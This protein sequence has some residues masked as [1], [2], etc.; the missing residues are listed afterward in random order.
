MDGQKSGFFP[1]FLLLHWPSPCNLQGTVHRLWRYSGK[2]WLSQSSFFV[3]ADFRQSRSWARETR[4][5]LVDGVFWSRVYS[6]VYPFDLIQFKFNFELWSNL[7]VLR[8][9]PPY[10]VYG[11]L[12]GGLQILEVENQWDALQRSPPRSFSHPDSRSILELIENHDSGI[13]GE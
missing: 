10:G 8:N 1:S 13:S 12:L 6:G 3:L 5:L 2:V 11:A 4:I 7:P 9:I